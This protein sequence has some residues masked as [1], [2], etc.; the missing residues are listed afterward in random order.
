MK[1]VGWFRKEEDQEKRDEFIRDY[2]DN[3]VESSLKR[4][5]EIE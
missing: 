2:V 5:F 3:H 1:K 4:E